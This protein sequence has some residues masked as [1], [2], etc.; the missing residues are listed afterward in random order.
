VIFISLAFFLHPTS[1]FPTL[2]LILFHLILSSSKTATLRF[3]F[4]KPFRLY[5]TLNWAVRLLPL[6][7]CNR[8]Q[9]VKDD[10]KAMPV[11]AGRTCRNLSSGE[12][13]KQDWVVPPAHSF[14]SELYDSPCFIDRESDRLLCCTRLF[15]LGF[16]EVSSHMS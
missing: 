8:L 16:P 4:C 13:G 3:C 15:A 7:F 11:L 5:Q 12:L 1:D 6:F 10:L 9:F 14:G 2:Q